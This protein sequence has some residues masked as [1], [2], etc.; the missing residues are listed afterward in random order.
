MI[1]EACS[2]MLKEWT[3]DGV[4]LSPWEAPP[5]ISV[6][7]SRPALTPPHCL[8]TPEDILGAGNTWIGHLPPAEN[9]M[10][11]NPERPD[12]RF[13]GVMPSGKCFRCCPFVGDVVLMGKVDVLLW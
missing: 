8:S 3:R 10:K 9:F 1:P 7:H 2:Q 12:V 4:W 11:E 13:D 5:V 6:T